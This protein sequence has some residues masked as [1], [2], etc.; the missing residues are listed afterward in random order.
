M[1]HTAGAYPGFRSI[2]Q[3]GVFILPP[4]WDGIGLYVLLKVDSQVTD[5]NVHGTTKK[6]M[7]AYGTTSDKDM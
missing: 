6:C 2:K 5:I 4:G 1:A 3:L 7:R